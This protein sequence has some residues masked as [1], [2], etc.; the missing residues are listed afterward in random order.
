MELRKIMGAST[1]SSGGSAKGKGVKG[2]K[3][4]E[5]KTQAEA[6]LLEEIAKVRAT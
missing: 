5:A 6:T 2:D 3:A 1:K 4:E